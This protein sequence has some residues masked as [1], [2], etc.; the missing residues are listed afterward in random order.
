MVVPSRGLVSTFVGVID[1][2]AGN[3]AGG[4]PGSSASCSMKAEN[5]ICKPAVPFT[6]A[7]LPA[8]VLMLYVGA[9][10]LD[11]RAATKANAAA[12][13]ISVTAVAMRRFE[14]ADL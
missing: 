11:G 5:R 3:G 6:E 9:A 4:A 14:N 2:G 8:S 13:D 10:A 7:T 1:V 12:A